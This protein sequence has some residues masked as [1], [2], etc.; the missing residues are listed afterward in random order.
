MYT[1]RTDPL[2]WDGYRDFGSALTG[3][4]IG[5]QTNTAFYEVFIVVTANKSTFP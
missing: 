3:Q 4:L 2:H 1:V 5:N